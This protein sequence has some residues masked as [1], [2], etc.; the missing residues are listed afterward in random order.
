MNLTSF[1]I[2]PSD[3]V[4][5][6]LART[7]D[8]LPHRFPEA[9]DESDLRLLAK[10]F[11]EPEAELASQMQLVLETPAQIA[12][13]LGR[14]MRDVAMLL[15]EMSKKGLI[16]L[17][18]TSEG[19]LGFSLMPFV[20]GI[21]E[22]QINRM[23][24]EMA[25]LFEEYYQAAFHRALTE[26]PQ[27]HR[28][29]PV[30]ESVKNNMEV[31]P[32]ESASDIV[33]TAQSW[34][35]VDCICR[36]QKALI[37]YPCEHPVDVCMVLSTQPG[38]FDNNVTGIRILNRDE[39]LSTLHRAAQAGLVHC[40]SNNQKEMWYIC[41]CC[42]CSCSVLRG[43]AEMG[44]A[45][46]VARSAF[47]NQVDESL[48]IGCGECL[49]LCQF[50]AL[51]LGDVITVQGIRCVGCGLCVPVCP[52]EALSLVRRPGEDAP[53]ETEEAWRQVRRSAKLNH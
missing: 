3:S 13:R 46:V 36:T 14:D 28:V 10:L 11:S 51:T 16:T 43:M 33:E 50:N 21:Y 17:G 25:Q 24:A 52:Q 30:G 19:R 27:V 41:N 40:V 29:I 4:Y 26:Q 22:A 31:R 2:F 8:S 45:N 6:R 48:C 1:P 18:K 39:A 47:V 44:I 35:V 20:V 34:G 9:E 42:T 23:D 7:L 53:P 32:F 38:A 15:K 12:E 37:G 5:R 49:D